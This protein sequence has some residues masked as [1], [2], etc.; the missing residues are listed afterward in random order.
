[1]SVHQLTIGDIEC[2]VL[3]EGSA[4]MTVDS[5]AARYPNAS[6][7]DIRAALG[8]GQPSGSLNLLYINSGGA[9]VLA[10]V[11]F[12]ESGPPGMGG[13]LRGLQSMGMSP[14]DIDIVYLTHFHGDHIAGLF[15]ADGT[16]VYGNAR[17]VTMQEEW[18]EWMGRWSAA[19]DQQQLERFGGLRERFSFVGAGDEVAPGVTVVNLE[20]HTLGHSGLL[21]DSGGERLL[22]AVDLLHQ[23]F[24]FART[25][26]H[27]AFDSDAELAVDTRRRELQRCVDEGLLTLFYH[28]AFPG[29][30]HVT[31]DGDTF[32]WNPIG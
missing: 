30:G 20:G 21:L 26:W 3:H 19:Q 27:F 5:I 17:Y 9:R 22:H 16:P 2:A 13:V 15:N 14:A 1:M 28:L 31:V 6:P 10:D 25:G 24:Q 4:K 29:L 8:G 7:S 12:G 11:A 32:I 23:P 18:D